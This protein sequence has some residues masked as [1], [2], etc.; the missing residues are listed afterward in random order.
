ML[1]YLT[2]NPHS[3]L[4]DE[5]AGELEI[6]VKKLVGRFYLRSFVVK[7]IRNYTAVR[8]FVVDA[9][10]TDD[11]AEDFCVALQSFRMMAAARIIVLLTGCEDKDGYL[12]RLQAAGITDIVTEDEAKS[13]TNRL[14][15]L[16]ADRHMCKGISEPALSESIDWNA[17]NVRIAFARMQRR[18]GTTVTA[19][20]LAFWLTA[21]GAAVCYVEANANRHLPVIL[22]LYEDKET[23]G[24]FTIDGIDF[25][26][27][28]TLDR[29]YNFIIY[30]CGELCTVPEAFQSAD[31]R[32]LCSSALPYEIQNFKRAVSLCGSL[33]ATKILIGVPT[34]LKAYCAILM[35]DVQLA[36]ISRNLFDGRINGFINKEIIKE[37]IS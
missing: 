11:S 5:A 35:E 8:Y 18:S 13:V 25:Y 14:L 23:S 2:G 9:A 15:E 34:E 6:G 16:L 1:L 28:D 24:H 31:K 3:R 12:S 17:H 36:D 19:F 21:H 30:D 27:N 7:E 22:Q 4:I 10:C 26:L 29:D 32:I 37:Y 20:N 33:P